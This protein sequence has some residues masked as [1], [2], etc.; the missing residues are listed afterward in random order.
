MTSKRAAVI[1]SRY[2]ELNNL[3]DQF[4]CEKR[5]GMRK[6][7]VR[8]ADDGAIE[9]EV[10]TAC[11]CHPEYEWVTV[12]TAEEFSEWMKKNCEP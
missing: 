4:A 9:M 2:Q 7:P 6:G 11:H 12:A 1:L 8:F 10:N 5:K 3:A